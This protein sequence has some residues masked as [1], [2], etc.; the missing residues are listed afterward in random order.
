MI[1]ISPS[2]NRTLGLKSAIEKLTDRIFWLTEADKLGGNWLN[3][4]IFRRVGFD[5]KYPLI[6]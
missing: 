3:Q 6:D 5:G 4:P 2:D 1:F